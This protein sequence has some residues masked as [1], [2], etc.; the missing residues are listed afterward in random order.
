MRTALIA[1]RGALPRRVAKGLAGTDWF[2]CHLDGTVPDGVGQ[3]R[4]FRLEGIGRFVTSLVEDGVSQVVFAGGIDRPT[5]DPSR[6]DGETQVL[7]PR[8]SAA[9]RDGDDGALRALIAVFEDAGLAVTAPQD[10]DPTLIDLPLAGAPSE[11]DLADIAH[12]VNVH[13]ALSP[14]DVGQGLVVAAGQVLVVETAPGTDFMLATLAEG[15]PR[16]P[17]P[18]GGG[19][20][21]F[22]GAADWLS[23]G[24]MPA[25]LPAF[26][27]PPGGVFFKAPKVGQDR[28]IDLPAI[29]PET[30]RRCA[31]AGLNGLALEQDGVFVLEPD[32]VAAQ[33]RATGL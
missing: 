23:G 12:A 21:L 7:L 10:V 19:F 9:L 17:K 27:R 28:R 6:V 25:G 1:G 26:E 4:A 13:G 16:P 11:A 20:D 32:D 24:T 8:I 31:A 33:L 14:W 22:G 5:F 2:A 18:A 3:S 30:I 15:P 29:G